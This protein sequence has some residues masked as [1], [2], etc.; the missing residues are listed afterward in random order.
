MKTVQYNDISEYS[1]EQI[2]N[3]YFMLEEFKKFVQNGGNLN[4][5]VKTQYNNNIIPF[6]EWFKSR[7]S[8]NP[9][10]LNILIKENLILNPFTFIVDHKTL[11][12][13][14]SPKY[15]LYWMKNN[16]DIYKENILEAIKNLSIEIQDW[17]LYENIFITKRIP[18]NILDL[19]EIEN[20]NGKKLPSY[21]YLDYSNK[22]KQEAYRHPLVTIALFLDNA[23]V[24]ETILQTNQKYKKLFKNKNSQY[25]LKSLMNSGYNQTKSINAILYKHGINNEIYHTEEYINTHSFAECI[26][27]LISFNELQTLKNNI[28][29][30]NFEKLEGSLQNN[31]LKLSQTKEMTEF[32]INNNAI[33]YGEVFNNLTEKTTTINSF[34]EINN[35]EVFELVIEKSP[36]YKKMITEE[37][38]TFYK[39]FKDDYNN[40]I[41]FQKLKLITEKYNFPLEKIEI[42]ELADNVDIFETLPWFLENG[43]DPRKCRSFISKCSTQRADGLKKL[44]ALKKQE[45]FNS[46]YPDP[47][48]NLLSTAVTKDFFTWLDKAPIE[49]FSRYT[50]YGEPA[51]WGFNN[52]HG[53]NLI[54]KKIEDFN[55]LS[56]KGYSLLFNMVKKNPKR[57]YSPDYDPYVC[58][59][60]LVSKN[61]KPFK[62]S[63]QDEKGNNIFHYLLNYNEYTRKNIDEKYLEHILSSPEQTGE[64]LTQKNKEGVFPLEKIEPFL[65]Y[66]N[67]IYSIK[68]ILLHSLNTLDFET[69]L[70]INN[71]DVNIYNFCL[72]L[73]KEEPDNI[74]LVNK[75][76]ESKKLYKDLNKNLNQ[77]STIK[78]TK[79]LKV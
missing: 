73:F 74:N 8:E 49:Q 21:I 58:L 70:T 1:H 32:L 43:A 77:E 22:E 11:Q 19:N 26:S 51:W 65:K 78:K 36:E 12:I 53:F 55:Q 56:N 7:Y 52:T 42:F 72:D 47:I 33:I 2:N 45:L 61:K 79:K 16:F 15:G 64:L 62:I 41:T 9:E 68:K 38:I 69:I 18:R 20:D 48:Y 6:D 50:I 17:D 35:I 31:F 39:L 59:D 57:T 28:K 46:Y 34:K 30:I 4:L 27:Q 60:K 71:E 5:D 3:F 76:Y 25:F 37:P 63:G 54:L 67:N 14:D 24:Y 10:Y 13:K 40:K 29:H 75:I 44:K 23:D 66:S